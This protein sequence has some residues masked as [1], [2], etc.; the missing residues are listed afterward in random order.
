MVRVAM[1]LAYDG[2]HVSGWQRQRHKPSLQAALESALSQVAATEITVICAGRTDKGVHATQQVVH[3]DSSRSRSLEA[4]HQGTNHFLP[5]YMTVQWV[6]E[7]SDDFHA[8]YRATFRRYC[9]LLYQSRE[10]LSFFT[11]GV[12]RWSMPLNVAAMRQALPYLLGNQDFSA[13]RDRQCQAVSPIKTIEHCVLI[14]QG[15]LLILDIR[16]DAFLHHMVRN[17]MGTLLAI[18][19]QRQPPEWMQTII[20]SRDRK[21]AWLTAPPNGLYLVEVGYPQDFEIP[22]QLKLPWFLTAAPGVFE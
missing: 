1:G 8:R 17:I 20:E 3:F 15:P 14:E 18:G 5:P 16:A 22:S 10:P 11:Q 7:V 13:F 21:A 19:E 2:S 9:Y 12:T 4:W 6:K